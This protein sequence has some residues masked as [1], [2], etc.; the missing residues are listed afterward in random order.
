[1]SSLA[2]ADGLGP[3][4]QTAIAVAGLDVRRVVYR[5]DIDGLRAVAVLAVVAFHAAPDLV[6][7]GFV[8]VDVFFVISG[9]LITGFLL[10]D[11][12]RHEL[13]LRGFFAR[14]IRRIFPALIVVLAAT[15]LLGW[16]LLLTDEFEQLGRHIAAAAAFV[17]NFVFLGEVG[18]F[19]TFSELKPLLHLWSLAV[20]EQFY[21]VWPMLLAWA[22]AKGRSITLVAGALLVVSLVLNIIL[23]T[24]HGPA[25]FFLLP[26]RL[27]ELM[28]GGLLSC[29]FR[30]DQRIATT[31]LSELTRDALA[32]IGL[33]LV[34]TAFMALSRERH[35]P[36]AWALLPVIGTCC[37]IAGGARAWINRTVLAH[38]W[39]V[40]VGLISYPLY[41]WHWPALAFL[42]IV[43]GGNVGAI[44][45]LAA[46]AASFALAASTFIWIERP[47]RS[48]RGAAMPWTLV[49]A[50]ATVGAM[51]WAG[52][53]GLIHARTHVGGFERFN[54]AVQDWDFPGSA[55]RD[56]TTVNGLRVTSVGT[57]NR[58]I[59]F[60][61]DSNAQ[62]YGPRMEKLVQTHP[63]LDAQV[64]FATD[65]G[66]PPMRG[67]RVKMREC[68]AFADTVVK[69]ARDSEVS[70]VVI[71]AQWVGYLN[72][73]PF[74]F[75]RKDGSEVTGG[76]AFDAAL[77]DF[78]AM[79]RDL[80]AKG[81]QVYFVLNIPVAT[82]LDPRYVLHRRW[83]GDFEIRAQGLDRK[84]WD[85]G[86]EQTVLRLAQTARSAGATVINPADALCGP[87]V[88]PS[89]TPEGEPI[90]RD[91]FHLRASYV[92][93]RVHYLDSILLSRRPK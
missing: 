41:L 42:R 55:F 45:T 69:F 20:E 21:L 63:E 16:Y 12:S 44:Q 77:D 86:V 84:S 80:R 35:Y 22:I 62:Q 83:S 19:D 32:F 61:G 82:E 6:P 90:Y 56:W 1:M 26:T 47:I 7:G 67:V 79:V 4:R 39:L 46:L 51:G 27:W 76:P 88:C 34:V 85:Q 74:V 36:G 9:F 25:A 24:H 10:A 8:G 49:V 64:I 53:Y 17:V 59:L 52:A 91:G 65:G 43:E 11:A 81:K 38:R 18:Y 40:F 23:A 78:G 73:T 48:G 50:M 29:R 68:E 3:S 31:P 60:F 28:A 15:L 13:M 70:T 37:L 66:C 2:P 75:V 54:E 57:G 58:Q 33:A 14:R 89:I 92:R 93:E 72:S 87:E 71:V 5:P 30:G